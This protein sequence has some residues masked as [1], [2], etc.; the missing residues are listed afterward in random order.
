V[1][2]N[3]KKPYSRSHRLEYL[4]Q[5]ELARLVQQTSQDPRFSTVSIMSVNL[6]KDLSRADVYFSTYQGEQ[7]LEITHALNKAAG[8]F[9]NQL[10]QNISLRKVPILKFIND[11]SLDRG[12]HV[13]S[14]IQQ[15]MG[16]DQSDT[17]S[18]EEK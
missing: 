10:A 8:F 5:Q 1:I 14:L 17:S 7:A 4:L 6:S 3:E 16:R 13:K 2:V 12:N 15:A 11:D 9:Q 18:S